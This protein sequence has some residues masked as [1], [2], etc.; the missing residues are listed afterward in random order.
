MP[1]KCKFYTAGAAG[2]QTL[3]CGATPA[4]LRGPLENVWAESYAQLHKRGAISAKVNAAEP[5][6]CLY[7]V[8]FMLTKTNPYVK[9]LFHVR[10]AG[11]RRQHFR[12]IG[13]PINT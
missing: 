4:L 11:L 12:S 10:H 8:K 1:Q 5:K 9:N 2:L 7:L 3:R 6:L 13:D